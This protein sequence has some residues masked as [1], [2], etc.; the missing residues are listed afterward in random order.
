M[1]LRTSFSSCYLSFSFTDVVKRLV[2]AGGQFY[3]MKS[4]GI[5]VDTPLH[6]AV[7]LSNMDCINELLEAGASIACLD[8]QGLTPLHVCVKKQLEQT[9][10]VC[11][12]LEKMENK[13]NNKII[14]KLQ[15]RFHY[16]RS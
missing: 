6:T 5:N 13:Y 14:T 10:K 9:L 7:E 11:I 3:S 8:S 1:K 4:V 15:I 2:T 12:T 16:F